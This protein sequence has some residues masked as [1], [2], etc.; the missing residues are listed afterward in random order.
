MMNLFAELD[1]H[2]R[3]QWKVHKMILYV[4]ELDLL[5]CR[6]FVLQT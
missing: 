4:L 2:D 5:A 6:P 1:I 3:L